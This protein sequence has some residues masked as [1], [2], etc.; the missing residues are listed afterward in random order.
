MEL[1]RRNFLKGTG[2]AALAATFGQWV[3]ANPAQAYTV[4]NM[5][6]NLNEAAQRNEFNIA[7]IMTQWRTERPGRRAGLGSLA[8]KKGYEGQWNARCRTVREAAAKTASLV[9][10]VCLLVSMRSCSFRRNGVHRGASRVWRKLE[11][12]FHRGLGLEAP[13]LLTSLPT[14]TT[15]GPNGE[16]LI[17]RCWVRARPKQHR[18]DPA[19]F[20]T[21]RASA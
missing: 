3:T 16:Y 6:K 15:S 17:Q 20:H 9:E 21:A 10:D 7:L 19:N 8:Q 2:A 14:T 13:A 12:R 4:N 18:A 11:F 1:S 5:Y